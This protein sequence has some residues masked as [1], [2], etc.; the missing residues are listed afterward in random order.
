M[1]E[2]IYQSDDLVA[3]EKFPAPLWRWLFYLRHWDAFLA[4]TTTHYAKVFRDGTAVFFGQRSGSYEPVGRVDGLLAWWSRW[5]EEVC[6]AFQI[7]GLPNPNQVL[8]PNWNITYGLGPDSVRGVFVDERKMVYL[9]QPNASRIDIYDLETG[10]KTEEINHNTGEYFHALAWVQEGQVAGFCKSSGKVR[11][12]TYLGG[13]KKVIEADRIDPFLLAAY[14]SE[15]HLFFAVGT[16][17]RARVYCR[18]AWSEGLSA[19]VFEPATV[20]GLKANRLK[21]RLTGDGGK[22]IPDMWVHWDLEGVNGPVIGSLDKAVSKTDED[23]WAKNIYY[24]PDEGLTG[25][26]KVKVRTV[27]F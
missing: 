8:N 2:K 7:N 10:Q 26:N 21:T 12:M 25:W 4:L 16:D 1:Y 15:H 19:P 18:E 27:L 17:Y 20:Y 5:T 24:G 6:P 9:H 23:G 3:T 14:D 11:I 13:Q 22:P